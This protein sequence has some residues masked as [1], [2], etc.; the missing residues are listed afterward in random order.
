MKIQILATA[1]QDWL[2]GYGFYEKQAEGVGAYFLDALFLGYAMIWRPV[3]CVASFDAPPPP[4][5]LVR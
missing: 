1:S 3:G 2:D 4:D 5:D